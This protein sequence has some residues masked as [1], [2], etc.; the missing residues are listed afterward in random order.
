MARVVWKGAIVFGMVYIPVSLYPGSRA[1]QLDFNL[2]DRRDHAPVGYQR[3]N[4]KTGKPV[5]W[6]NIVKGYEYE[7]GQFVLMSDEDFRQANPE[8]TQTV[9]ILSF[10][11]AGAI[12]PQYFD[13]PYRLVPAKRGEKGYALLRET[14]R[15]TGRIGVAQVVI[16]TKQHLA[17]VMPVDEMLV[18]E[19]LRYGDEILPATEFEFPPAEIRK[20]GIGERELDMATRLVEEMT[21]EWD[22]ARFHDTYREDLMA[23]IEKKI[24]SGDTQAVAAPAAEAKGEIAGGAK[25]IDLMAALKRSLESAPAKPKQAAARRGGARTSRKAAAPPAASKRKR[26]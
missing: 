7:D 20:A 23:R 25:V 16:R 5:D 17:A 12:D 6:E 22:P 8:A 1:N 26:A 3:I 9:E 18:L 21:E 24:Q 2:L 4:K 15:R 10:V 11:E 14:L 19:T 13:T